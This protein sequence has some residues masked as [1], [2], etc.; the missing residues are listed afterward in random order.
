MWIEGQ[1][2]MTKLIV[3]FHGFANVQDGHDIGRKMEENI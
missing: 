1:M 3:A 2:D